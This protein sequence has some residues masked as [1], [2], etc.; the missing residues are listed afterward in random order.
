MKKRSRINNRKSN[1]H[2]FFTIILCGLR[3]YVEPAR[4][5]FINYYD[6]YEKLLVI[7]G[8]LHTQRVLVDG[9]KN[10]PL[11]LNHLNRLKFTLIKL[12]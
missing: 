12:L 9:L 4:F 3:D 10:F 11:V 5:A 1:T 8:I 6:P 2:V 7:F